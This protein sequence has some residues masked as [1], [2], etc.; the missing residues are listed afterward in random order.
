MPITTFGGITFSET[1]IT[2]YLIEEHFSIKLKKE[3]DEELPIAFPNLNQSKCNC[4]KC[5]QPTT[6]ENFKIVKI[7]D[8]KGKD[9]VHKDSNSET[10]S[11]ANSDA[12]L[13]KCAICRELLSSICIKCQ[14]ELNKFNNSDN[15]D[16][17]DNSDKSDKSDN[18]TSQCYIVESQS[19][20]HKFHY[21][22]IS[23]WLNTRSVC[24][25]CN[26]NWKFVGIEETKIVVHYDDQVGE[27]DVGTDNLV[28]KIGTKF[29]LDMDKN[30][31]TFKKVYVDDCNN[32]KAG[33]YALCTP[34]MH[35]GFNGLKIYCKFGEQVNPFFVKYSTTITE[36]REEI[37]KSFD[38]FKDQIRIIYKDQE[39]GK[40]F[41]NLNIFN[42]DIASES[43]LIIESSITTEYIME[44][45][46]D[47]LILYPE[48]E[49]NNATCINTVQNL[50]SGKISW[51]PYPFVKDVTSKQELSCLLSCLYILIKKVNM[52]EDILKSVVNKFEKYMTL[53]EIHP[54][55]ISLAVPA[56]ESLLRMSNFDD[57]KRMILSNTFHELIYKMQAESG[58]NDINNIKNVF[59]GTNVLCNLL[60]SI[61]PAE[62]VNWKFAVK[63]LRTDKTFT[64]YSPLVL[65]NGVPPLL[66]L[67][68]N[69]NIVVF[70]GKGKDVSLPIILYNPLSDSETDVN[71][72]ELGQKVSNKG[73][74]LLVDD[75]IYEEGIMVCIDTSNSMGSCSDFQ[76]DKIAKKKDEEEAQKQFYK[77]LDIKKSPAPEDMD[78]RKLQNTIIWFITHPNFKDWAS[79]PNFYVLNNIIC[80][81]QHDNLEMAELMSKYKD[82]FI[83]L[84]KNQS[85]SVGG[86]NYSHVRNEN[87]NL[88]KEEVKYKSEPIGEFLCPILHEIMTDP[89]IAKDGFTYE[90]TSI[91]KWFEKSDLSPMIQK[92]IS[93]ELT[94]NKTLRI[95]IND[96]KA[97]NIMEQNVGNNEQIKIKLPEPWNEI[98]IKY[99][100]DTNLWDLVYKIY[101]LTGYTH[102]EFNLREDWRIY[103]NTEYVKNIKKEIKLQSLNKTMITIK[104]EREFTSYVVASL[105][106]PDYYSVKNLIYRSNPHEYHM[107]ELWSDLKDDGDG[108]YKGQH[109][110]PSMRL[111]YYG[112]KTFKIFRN[113]K[114]KITKVNYMSRLDV[115]KKLFD[116]FINRSIAYSFN[117]SIGLMSFSDKSKVQCEM[118]PFYESFRDKM[119]TLHPNGATALYES[120]KQAVEKLVFWKNADPEKRGNAKLRIICLSDGKDTGASSL[121]YDV[122]SLMVQ[123]NITLDC[124]VIGSDF[125]SHIGKISKKTRGY[126][127]NPSTIKHA[128]DI[129][130]LETMIISKNREVVQSS[131]NGIIG[132]TTLPPIVTPNNSLKQKAMDID[133][134]LH[135]MGDSC[136]VIQKELIALQKNP[137]PDIDVYI[138]DKDMYFWKIVIKGPNGTPYQNGCYLAYIQFPQ[139]Y[140]LVAPNIRFVTPIKHCNINNYGRVC[141][142]ILDRNYVPVIGISLIL[143]CIYGLLLNPDVSDPLDTN[144][145]LLYYEANGQYEADILE[146]VNK[147]ASKTREQWKKE[148]I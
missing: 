102:D 111:H 45:D 114:Q 125:D 64:I 89:F 92:K 116:A 4:D 73:E 141:H 72:A 148:L 66:T 107:T 113:E 37:S 105:T 38:L 87:I 22:C 86:N 136:K 135:K 63:D 57:K 43:T 48:H 32:I 46:K 25:T 144:M 47:F 76:E 23:R 60:L 127:F 39:I 13:E 100:N 143:N 15:L 24:P 41:N 88:E 52:N 139:T 104:L 12:D 94:E 34:D 128:F 51:L 68:E 84:L 21:C 85:V 54:I 133:K 26:N 138:N 109:I 129:M 146:N 19:C 103:V 93:K 28:D 95:I 70:T 42:V 65:V 55:Q 101:N 16:N 5:I 90:K 91:E 1:E 147:Y 29:N 6:I 131:Y 18:P 142:S 40:D 56:L 11:D 7:I 108:L 134:T 9:P 81:E 126:M 67:N 140:P 115:V 31:L 119:D 8:P 75:R 27:F 33:K 58:I 99:K 71:A 14:T 117:T 69:M 123:N 124:I 145:A 10:D 106:I 80:A 112:D 83:K 122:D 36:L 82:I 59:L 96:W 62:K 20:A 110:S 132:D 120:L 17:S 78:L 121:K 79:C 97:N 30:K 49:K 50:I 137:H 44:I 35:A 61:N 77:I 74:T 3:Y 118:T 98:S 53:Y 130:E 2:P